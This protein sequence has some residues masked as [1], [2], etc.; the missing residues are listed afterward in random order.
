V[1]QLQGEAGPQVSTNKTFQLFLRILAGPLAF[2]VVQAIPL[3]GLDPRAHAALSCYL[4]VLAWWATTPIPWAVTGFLPL[5]LFPIVGAM[6]FADTIGLY[7]QRIFPFL[8]GVMLFGHAFNKHGLAKRMAMAV[9]S[10]PGVATS[11]ARLILM[12]MIVSAIVSSVVDDAA[13]VAIMIPIA[14]SVARFAAEAYAKTAGAAGGNGG[15]TPRLTEASCLAVLYGASAGG[16][17]TPAG[18]PFNPLTISLL[19]QLTG[20][21]VSFAQWTLTGVIL[22]AAVIPVYYVILWL[23]S[24]PE[25]KSI[26]D[27][28]SYF[29]EEKKKLGPLRQGEKNVLFVLA[30]MIILWLLPAFVTIGVVDIWYVPPLAMV[31]LFLL[32][33][34]AR[35]GEMTVV[36]KDFQDGVLWNVL[37]LVVSGTA[38]AAGLV[39]LGVTDWFG[40]VVTRNVSAAVLPWFAGLVTPLIAHV[41]SGTATTSML[42]TILFPVARDLGYNPTILARIIAGTALAVSFPWAG[43]AVGTAFASG[44]ISF[45]TLFR[46]GVVATVLTAIVITVLSMILVPA[47]GAFTAP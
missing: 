30:L 16:M 45:G 5:I 6:P 38:I 47:L 26:A 44:A 8:L 10:I 25:V 43:A 46:V 19:D 32:P 20:Y 11:G 17:A 31:L 37:F 23:M 3:A 1:S 35:T 9:L 39:R 2:L 29:S 4:W 41:G 12:I 27:G 22:M 28:A 13:T 36:S 21:K 15:K 18:V 40:G 24:P 7:G 33:V 34:N 14:L 42:S